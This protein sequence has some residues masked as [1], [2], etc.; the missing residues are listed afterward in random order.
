MKLLDRFRDKLAPLNR[1]EAEFAKRDGLSLR[2]QFGVFAISMLAIYLR[3]PSDPTHAQ[4]FA[5]DGTAW[6]A[7]AYNFGGLCSFFALY[8]LPCHCPTIGRMAIFAFSSRNCATCYVAGRGSFS[9]AS[10]SYPALSPVQAVGFFIASCL[11]RGDLYFDAK[12]F[13]NSCCSDQLDVASCFAAILL[14]FAA[15]PQGWLGRLFDAVIFILTS[16]T[17]PFG[18]L[19]APVVLLFRYVRRHRWSLAAFGLL[20]LGGCVQLYVMHRSGNRA[21]GPLGATPGIFVRLTAGNVFISG[22]LGSVSWARLLPLSLLLVCF[23]AGLSVTLYFIWHSNL[24]LR[25]FAVCC[26]GIFL[27]GLGSPL[28]KANPFGLWY[29]LLDTAGTRYWF[30]ATLLFLWACCWCS[31]SAPARPWRLAGALALLILPIGIVHNW[32]YL[33]FPD[34]HLALYQER[35]R[36][37]A[38]GQ[39]IV[40]PKAPANWT[41]ELVK[42]GS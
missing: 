29:A 36:Q 23:L 17:G 28:A 5:E 4:F 37:A 42:R 35:L 21:S 2:W 27:A 12:C 10:R 20:S 7:N 40:I 19:L 39:H 18:I 32:R 26:G 14:S 34:E 30:F 22:L 6:Y 1:R 33:P 41:M 13:G 16:L 31:L 3:C 24:E 9:M 11:L 8:Q 15:P 38:P 25:L